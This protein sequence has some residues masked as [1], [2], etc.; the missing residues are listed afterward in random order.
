MKRDYVFD[1]AERALASALKNGHTQFD[2]SYLLRHAG[3]NEEAA[4][5]VAQRA[6]TY[7]Q[8]VFPGIKLRLKPYNPNTDPKDYSVAMVEIVDMTNCK[9]ARCLKHILAEQ[10]KTISIEYL[11]ASKVAPRKELY[12]D[13]FIKWALRLFRRV[14]EEMK[15]AIKVAFENSRAEFTIQYLPT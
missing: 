4:R 8:R 7:L 6:I 2:V 14:A 5:V 11:R 10:G 9:L 15:V 13:R 3:G 12:I 1:G